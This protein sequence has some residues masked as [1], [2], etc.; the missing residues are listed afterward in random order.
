M[1]QIIYYSLSLQG[2]LPSVSELP[3]D[4]DNFLFSMCKCF[5]HEKSWTILNVS[6]GLREPLEEGDVLDPQPTTSELLNMF[7]R[8]T[9]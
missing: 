6:R 5:D 9:D 3:R 2:V 7:G 1:S 4:V 8:S